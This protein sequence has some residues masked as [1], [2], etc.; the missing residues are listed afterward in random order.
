MKNGLFEKEAKVSCGFNGILSNLII[1]ILAVLIVYAVFCRFN[2][3]PFM[4][5]NYSF[6]I[7]QSPSMEPE[8]KK[9]D[10]VIVKKIKGPDE[11]N[12]GDI[13]TYKHSDIIVTHRISE[14]IINNGEKSYLTKGDNNP[15]ADPWTVQYADIYGKNIGIVYFLGN[16]IVW[17]TGFYGMS[18][19]IVIFII[20]YVYKLL[21]GSNTKL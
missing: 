6:Y 11:I 21:S 2:N 10:F 9:N 16:I 18:A 1:L 5:F 19:A 13:I 8:I 20:L 15:S 17:L 3:K 12:T 14:I 7:I 4:F